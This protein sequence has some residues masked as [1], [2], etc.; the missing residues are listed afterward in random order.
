M[1]RLFF[2]LG[3]IA[4]I[5]SPVY[6][7]TLVPMV[8]IDIEVQS[9]AKRTQTNE[10]EDTILKPYFGFEVTNQTELFLVDMN[11]RL[12]QERYQDKTYRDVEVPEVDAYLGWKILPGRLLWSFEDS[13]TRG[14]ITTMASTTP[15]DYQNSNVFSTG[16]DILFAGAAWKAVVKL[17]YNDVSFS[18]TDDDDNRALTSSLFLNREINSYS[19]LGGVFYHQDTDYA[20]SMNE[21][22]KLSQMYLLYDRDLPYG[23]FKINLGSNSLS[24]AVSDDRTEPYGLISAYYA[25][26]SGLT[27]GASYRT[28]ISD[29]GANLSTPAA[30]T[31]EFTEEGEIS[32]SLISSSMVKPYQQDVFSL[33]FG[34]T[35]G[36]L[37]GNVYFF[38]ESDDY[39]GY[40]EKRDLEG[41]GF[42]F[43]MNIS[44]TMELSLS[45]G[46]TDYT[47]VDSLLKETTDVAELRLDYEI[48]RGLFI[49]LGV[50]RELR[51]SSDTIRDYENNIIFAG[52]GYRGE[53][54][55]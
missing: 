48:A 29:P 26:G 51:D 38:S 30:T 27:T 39:F 25:P 23:G 8:G 52:I 19:R 28:R 31:L 34:Y 15:D 5:S 35:I 20:S 2:Y 6:A 32:S 36:V 16:P 44:P 17:R 47:F 18:D 22:Y 54:R 49:N 41:I 50:S 33:Y 40:Q 45:A 4:V 7:Y 1:T 21:D 42:T 37:N 3:F 10:V 11:V 12:E 24:D 53:E 9:N 46:R 55:N 13:A 43:G 14:L